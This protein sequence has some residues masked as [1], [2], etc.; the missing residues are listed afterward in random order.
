M[1]VDKL[2]TDI[3]NS[4]NK[5]LED[6]QT[7]VSDA[8]KKLGN[9]TEIDKLNFHEIKNIAATILEIETKSLKED[10]ASLVAQKEALDRKLEKKAQELQET[11][12]SVF[13]A[14]ELELNSNEPALL[15]L[16][17]VK[18]QSID[19]YE[20]LS[21]LV[22][23]AIITA[24]ERDTDG[25]IKESIQEVIKDLTFEAI[26]EGSLNTIRIRKI[27]STILQ[28]AIDVAEAT[29][30]KAE[31]ILTATLKGMRSGLIHSIDR[32]KKRL[33]YMPVEAKHIL[34]ED[35]DT[36]MEDLNQTDVLFS[37]VVQ[38]QASENSVMINK[39]LIN[40]N[41]NM[42]YDLEELVYISKEAA[43]MMRERFSSFAKTAVSRA[44][45][46]LKSQAAQEAKRM[47]KQAWRVAKTA[48]G[49]AIKTAK[50]AMDKEKK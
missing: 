20:F 12:Y 47:G 15:K 17:Q 3:K 27:L 46:A 31:D 33:A 29:P 39:L 7:R 23:S 35:Y 22:E 37:Q 44:D 30:T 32:F 40:I 21:E 43:D 36:I 14:I 4:Y 9:E 1:E 38:T 11:K 24:L 18:L 8:I 6:I 41:K 2:T 42:R 45:T 16:H 5:T 25:D 49:S 28:C 13:N 19:L 50:G 48:L 26:K 10:V 34:I